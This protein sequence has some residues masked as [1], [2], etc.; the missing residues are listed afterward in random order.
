MSRIFLSHS[1]KDS[2]QAIALKSWLVQQDPPL[3]N[4]IFLDLDRHAGILP[5][6]KWK[7]ALRQANARCEAVICLLSTNWESS[8]E[9]KTEYRTAETLNKHIFCARLEPSTS[10]EITREWEW[11][12][13]FGDGPRTEIDIADGTGNPVF[14]LSEGLYR[15]RDGIVGAGIGA[16]SFVWPPPK[17]PNRAP[18]RGWEPL[19]E[20]DAAVFFGR[21]A[22]IIRGLD[23]LRRMR[24]S[25]VET[26]FVVL[27][28][29]GSGKSSFLRAGL[30]PRLRRDDRNFLVLDIVRPER[31][32]LTGESG[33]AHSIHALRAKM[34]LKEPDLG[35]IK[36]VCLGGARHVRDLLQ[37]VQQTATSALL[38]R[39]GEQ[40][41]PTLVLPVDQAE[42]LF[43][44]DAGSQ[45]TR[46]LDMVGRHARTDSAH[47]L[48]L[49]VTVT[50]RTDRYQ[51]L[52]TAPELNGVES[53]VFDDLRPMPRTQFKE[54]I[55]G[56][57][58]R[59]TEGGRPL[60]IEP[61]L[62]EQLLA[63]CT[64]GADTLPLLSLTLARLY[65]EYGGDG[66]VDLAEYRS[67]GEMR[68]V[69]ETEIDNLLSSDGTQRH[70]QLDQ[71]RAAFVPWLVSID[72]DNDQPM[73]R[74]A[75]WD[76]LPAD[77]KPLLHKLVDKRF[78]VRDTRDGTDVVEVAMESL[79]R[80]WDE[81]KG[82]LDEE[83]EN[84]KDAEA[85]ERSAAEWEKSHRNEAWLLDGERIS[86]AETLVA[87]PGFRHRLAGAHEFVDVSRQRQN[88]RMEEEEQR[89]ESVLHRTKV[90]RTASAA[91]L[92][93]ALVA[94]STIFLLHQ[95]YQ[96]ATAWRLVSEA[97]Q[98]LAGGRPGGDVR[99]LQQVLAAHE[100]R[101]TA[102][103]AFAQVQRD[104]L[105]IMENPFDADGQVV[106]VLSLATHGER[107]A[108]G[109]D[110]GSV[111]IYDL[112]TGEL[113][114]TWQ[115]SRKPA[116]SVAFSPDGKWLAATGEEATMKLLD[117]NTGVVKHTMEHNNNHPVHT[118]AFSP[119][120][121]RIVTGSEDGTV[122][123]WG[124]DGLEESV[125]LEGHLEGKV[126][127]GAVFNS[128]GDLIVSGGDDGSVKLW[129]ASDGHE[130]A[131]KKISEAPK[132]TSVAFSPD[133]DR[134]AAGDVGG[135][136][137]IL[138]GRD[139]RPLSD[140]V[141]AHPTASVN[142]V[143]FSPDGTRLVSGSTDNTIRSW[144][145]STLEP[146]RDPLT[147]H[148]GEVFSVAFSDNAE[149]V[150]GSADGSVR[151]W[152][153]I[154]GLPIPTGQEEVHAVAF[155]RDGRQI[156][157]GGDDGTVRL[158]DADTVKPFEQQLGTASERGQNT[159]RSVAFDPKNDRLVAGWKDGSIRLW[160]W[161]SG[162]ESELPKVSPG[163]SPSVNSVAFSPDGSR[164]AAGLNN[165]FVALWDAHSLKPIGA[166]N[167]DSTV[168]S[169]AFSQDGNRV[170]S[171]NH[172]GWVQLWNT[173]PFDR[174]T[175]AKDPLGRKGWPVYSV[176]FSPDGRTIAASSNDGSVRVWEVKT[177]KK[178]GDMSAD[179]N[180]V[181]SVA[182]AHDKPWI[183]SS[184]NTGRVHLWDA[185][186]YKPVGMPMTGK[187][188]F[189]RG[190]AFSP[191]DNQILTGS[192]DGNLHLWPAPQEL[193]EALCSKLTSNMSHKQWDDWVS[194]YIGYREICPGLPVPPND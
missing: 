28:P 22:Q 4:E 24:K 73:R 125:K 169:V 156:A 15:L 31:N 2:R 32:V 173:E 67:M 131:T 88:R 35:E 117:A 45:A 176:S 185:G 138:G 113:R 62:V 75:R 111:R 189:V 64:D 137:Q 48:P 148:H 94:V 151:K 120:S 123:L 55:T 10:A 26:L 60:W 39:P 167:A 170:V 20:V 158:W 194:P 168:Y 102:D 49:I 118:I 97:E 134:I 186:T 29:S 46:F 136:I 74:I 27:G 182:F 77:S 71:L 79:L 80:Q 147:G 40:K 76:D 146:I 160:N 122:R 86:K 190:V 59:A 116:W 162:E 19:E 174:F 3:A 108:S 127:R 90:I 6:L 130:I 104:V 42:E 128:S 187:Q 41:V 175:P 154:A 61:P 163:D 7:D 178:V 155:S 44:P 184:T 171:G 132:A 129:D 164:I 140:A 133:G 5:G 54:V 112:D 192:S 103:D 106:R 56:P 183:A 11:V 51:A 37:E 135:T 50:I 150:S 114:D 109:N 68:N 119:N 9:C 52:Q 8:A 144:D 91:A 188:V 98:I 165:G 36:E 157:S 69:V 193:T 58:T 53:V 100:L 18:Y 82:W 121:Q 1:S 179:Q 14:F 70:A 177:G 139:L 33:L 85:L 65:E 13:L 92:V 96:E 23:G 72:P 81:L 110:D 161:S 78:L 95:R 16:E 181:L 149:I 25:A 143:A 47:R 141:P 101:A 84:L 126:V 191:D 17:D 152:D 145:A 153:A 12:D 43:G 142:S 107:I 21:D 30:L 83:R 180:H 124:V 34:G 38:D 115:V 159:V 172:D 99:A 105:K 89:Q 87:Q 57:A 166:K 66:Q 93:M 63:D